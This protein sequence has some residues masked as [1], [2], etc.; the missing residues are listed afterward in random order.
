MKKLDLT[1]EILDSRGV[2][3]KQK[4][5][6]S[7]EEDGVEKDVL[8]WQNVNLG[9]VMADCVLYEIA[10]TKKI[11]E[12]EHL[13]RYDLFKRIRDNE[14]TEFSQEEIDFIKKL[15]IRRCMPLWA[16]QVLQ[17]LNKNYE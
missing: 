16:G 6:R 8:E 5:S 13:M 15:V 4:Y 1:Q 3:A 9:R 11:T 12:K 10:D 7:V 17:M 14:Q 2:V